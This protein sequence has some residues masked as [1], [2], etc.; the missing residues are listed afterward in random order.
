MKKASRR[1]FTPG[2]KAKVAM[3]ALKEKSTLAELTEKYEVSPV[4]ISRWKKEF[5]TNAA[6][7]FTDGVM[8][9]ERYQKE[10]DKLHAKIGELEMKLDFAKRVS[11]KLGIPIPAE[12]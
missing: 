4:L 3:E 2:F 12:D 1:K 10:R 5:I 7:A 9:E 6:A 8:S 11:E